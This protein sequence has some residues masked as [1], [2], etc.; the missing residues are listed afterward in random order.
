MRSHRDAVDGVPSLSDAIVRKSFFPK[1]TIKCDGPAVFRSQAA[2][3]VACLL[4][5][6]NEVMEWRCAPSTFLVSNNHHI[7]DFLVIDVHGKQYLLDAPDREGSS[8]ADVLNS[9]AAKAGFGYIRRGQAEVYDGCRLRNARDLLRYGNYEVGLVD[10]VR[11]LSAL[12]EHGSLTV[13]E[14]L[15]AFLETKP[16]AGLAS[17]ILH[18][19]IEVE[20]DA[21]LIGP[22]TIVRRIAV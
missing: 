10:R 7:C 4:D 12:E 11:L 13:L 1:A 15:P 16:V 19:F 5:V 17:M 6:D 9:A 20:L 2:R 21:E 14:C 8:S 18:G 3:D 22:S